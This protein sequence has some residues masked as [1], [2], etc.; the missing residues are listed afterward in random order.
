MLKVYETKKRSLLKAISFRA[1]EI[2]VDSL[3]LSLFVAPTI[4]ISLAVAL[5]SICFLLH[6]AFER[7][8]NKI[9]YGRY[10]VRE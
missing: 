8:W 5:E 6:F 4:A 7:V 3:M 2:A 9:N 10:V 1:I